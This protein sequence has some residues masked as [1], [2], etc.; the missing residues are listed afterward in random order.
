MCLWELC[1]HRCVFYFLVS[2][3]I[4]NLVA[5][6]P[7]VFEKTRQIQVIH[8]IPKLN[9]LDVLARRTQISDILVPYNDSRDS[10]YSDKYQTY[11]QYL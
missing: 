8:I 11:S 5:G 10:M 6:K 1:T 7:C 2:L 3:I 4:I 9:S